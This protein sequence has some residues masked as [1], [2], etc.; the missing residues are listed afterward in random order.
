MTARISTNLRGDPPKPATLTGFTQKRQMMRIYH[1]ERLGE[2]CVV[3][4]DGKP[5]ALRSD[6]SGNATTAYDWG[7]IGTGQLASALLS[8]LLGD[9][10]K[11]R[12]LYQAFEEKVVAE[13]PHDHWAMTEYEFAAAMAPSEGAHDVYAPHDDEGAGAAFGDMPVETAGLVAQ[14]PT[15]QAT[16]ATRPRRVYRSTAAPVHSASQPRQFR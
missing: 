12:A 13:L 7:Y 10:L 11:A 16:A 5:L 9:D 15:A 14:K 2:D 8:D 1:G 3:T 4:V 6:L